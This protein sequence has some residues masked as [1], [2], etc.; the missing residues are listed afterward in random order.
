MPCKATNDNVKE[1]CYTGSVLSQERNPEEEIKAF[2]GRRNVYDAS[3]GLETS[4]KEWF[5]SSDC[6]EWVSEELISCY[7]KVFEVATSKLR[8]C[9]AS[10]SNPLHKTE[11][12]PQ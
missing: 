7:C 9:L 3:T 10:R 8:P 11:P 5:K 2:A 6:S 12:V 1:L 4:T